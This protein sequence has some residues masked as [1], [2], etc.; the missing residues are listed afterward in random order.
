MKT[1]L[2][3]VLCCC[4][5]SVKAIAEHAIPKYE[6][7][8]PDGLMPWPINTPILCNDRLVFRQALLTKTGQPK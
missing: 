5:H 3:P 1:A 8:H 4:C 7:N 2:A 6:P